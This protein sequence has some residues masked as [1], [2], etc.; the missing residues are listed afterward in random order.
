MT[1]S[2]CPR[3]RARPVAAAL[4]ALASTYA[5]ADDQS[6]VAG[7]DGLMTFANVTVVNA[8]THTAAEPM[9]GAAGMRA[10][11]DADTGRL[12]APTAVE[13]QA[14]D[15]LTPSV[16]DEPVEVSTL[17]NGTTV[18]KLNPSYMSY[19]VV[20]KNAD[21]SL[22]EQCVTGESAASHALHAVA[23]DAEVS[24]DR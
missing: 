20:Q 19:S 24:H 22:T 10:Q 1:T 2:R 15:A 9:T 13:I 7:N 3:M 18:A 21:G 17:A 5:L 12:R 6:I 11:K 23:V 14:L 4:L 16:P 8:A